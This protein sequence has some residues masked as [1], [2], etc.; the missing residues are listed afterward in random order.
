MNIMDQLRENLRV[1]HIRNLF[2]KHIKRGYTFILE[3]DYKFVLEKF[4]TM[5]YFTA[6]F[7][8]WHIRI[9]KVYTLRD[10]TKCVHF[11]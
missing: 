9:D 2:L 5:S 11:H 10:G 3:E 7:V 4:G 6:H 8:D 1:K